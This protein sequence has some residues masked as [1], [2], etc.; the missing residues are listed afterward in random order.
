MLVVPHGSSEGDGPLREQL[1][2]LR[3]LLVLSMILTRQDDE[4]GILHLVARAVESLGPCWTERI[5]FSGRWTEIRVPEHQPPG[6]DLEET[7]P[8]PGGRPL[9]AGGRAM[10]VVLPDLEPARGVRLPRSGG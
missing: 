6:A 10:V 8:C 9:R 5:L 3:S 1:S 7:I 2:D 4:A